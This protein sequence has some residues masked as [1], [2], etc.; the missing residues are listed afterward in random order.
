MWTIT[1]ILLAS[2]AI[3]MLELPSLMKK[4]LYKEFV[5]VCCLVLLGTILSIA[6]SMHMKLPNPLDL[7]TFVYQPCSDFILG[8]LQ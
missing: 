3:A 7:I 8:F 4:K 6:Q 1:G 2:A 5:I